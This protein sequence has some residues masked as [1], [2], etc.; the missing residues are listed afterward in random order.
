MNDDH[1]FDA[2]D[3][4]DA[5]MDY[6]DQ[7]DKVSVAEY[8]SC[9]GFTPEYTDHKYGWFNL[10]TARVE[11]ARNSKNETV[12]VIRLPKTIPISDR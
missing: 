1:C 12:Y 6:L 10:T 4:L 11:R 9:C 3:V 5:L 2:D 8:V 7:Y